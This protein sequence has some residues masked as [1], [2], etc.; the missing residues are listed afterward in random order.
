MKKLMAILTLCLATTISGCSTNEAA[1]SDGWQS[2]FD[3]K[4]LKG[5]KQI[6]GSAKYEVV[7]GVIVGTSVKKSKN[8]FIATDKTYGDFIMEFESK[9]DSPLNSGVQFRSL[10]KASYMNGR[11]H[12]YQLEI[13][14]SNRAWTGGIFDEGRSKWLYP[15]SYNDSGRIAYKRDQW[16]KFRIEAIGTSLRTYVNGIPTANLVDNQTAEGFFALQVHGING[17]MSKLGKRV[18]WKNLR[19][20][21]ANLAAERWSSGETIAQVNYIPNQ[22]T[23]RQ[24]TAGW[25]LLWDGKTSK[26]WKG[27]KRSDFPDKGWEIKDGVLSVLSSGGA[28]AQN[29]GDIVTLEEFSDFELEV[30]FNITEGANSGIKYFVD[31]TLL[32]GKGSA[33]GLEFQILDD[34]KHKDAKKGTAGNRT[35]GSLYDLITAGNLTELERDKKRFNGVGSWNRARIVVQ[36]GKVEHWLNGV[37]TVEFDRHSQI[38]DALVAYSKYAKW[39]NFGG[40]EKGPIL[41]QDHGD[42]VHFR[43]IKIKASAQVKDK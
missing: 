11:V 35:I 8:S 34:K 23:P 17:D 7:D 25:K 40:W 29:G 39:P 38:F 36:G 24:K 43:T 13:D 6:N 5:W 15:L 31:P 18:R 41:L 28:E 9:V 21:T 42:L 33:I 10:S 19:I 2:L 16:N 37:Q 22:L 20:K 1:A 26:G 4:T 27:A 3:G 32:K 14:P 30:D 12:G